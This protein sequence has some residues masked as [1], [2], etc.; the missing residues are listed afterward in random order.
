M[1]PT[2]IDAVRAREYPGPPEGVFL[3]AASYG[4]L[5]AS[6]AEAAA[7]LVLRR[8]R[9][10][11][12]AEEELGEILARCRGAVA[13]LLDVDSADVALGPNTSYGVNL[14]VAC[15]ATFPP[16]TVLVSQGEFPANV[17][18][19]RALEP[20]GFEL[21]VVPTDAAG[22]PDEPAMLRRLAD[23][24][25]RVLALSTVQ[26]G[27]GYRADM[28]ALGRACRDRGVLFFVDA[29][30]ALGVV[31]VR[32]LSCGVDLLSSGGQ[33]WLCAPWGS[34][35]TWVH[36]RLR[37]RFEPPMVSWLGMEG[38]LEFDRPLDY[39][40][41]W[42]GDAAR[43]ELGTLGFQDYLGLARALEVLMEVGVATILDHVRDVQ[44]PLLRWLDDG[45]GRSLVTPREPGRRAGIVAFRVSDPTA[46]AAA[47]REAGVVFAVR[48][49]SL[50]FSP[51]FY[52]TVDEMR[53]VVDVLERSGV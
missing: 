12:F 45:T 26:F 41:R 19:W 44:E 35:F 17:L 18:P 37:E 50:R 40:L 2:P 6:A 30:Q 1:S 49:G 9:V 46:A 4:L 48:E 7:D 53:R 52:N 22:L 32:P 23:D 29:I 43:F 34:G 15:A 38:A 16:G 11:G 36:P 31:P 3:N 25:V 21:E 42:R 5:P 14:G 24:D 39:R 51:H 27:T 33:K 28:E 13:R 20:R 10:H 47:L 8:R